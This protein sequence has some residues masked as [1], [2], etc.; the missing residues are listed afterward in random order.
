MF[1]MSHASDC[2]SPAALLLN[3]RLPA[4]PQCLSEKKQQKTDNQLS[5]VEAAVCAR[6]SEPLRSRKAPENG[7]GVAKVEQS[8]AIK[9]SFAAE[10]GPSEKQT[11]GGRGRGGTHSTQPARRTGG[12][13]AREAR[14]TAAEKWLSERERR[15][16]RGRTINVTLGTF[17]QGNKVLPLGESQRCRSWR[18]VDVVQVALKTLKTF[19]VVKE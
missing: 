10:M 16:R 5:A 11:E 14:L 8:S 9:S 2:P 6:L 15:G 17:P 4:D 18:L 19:S 1:F 12:L 13:S 3:I 7:S